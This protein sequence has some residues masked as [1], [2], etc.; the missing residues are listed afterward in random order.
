MFP[1]LTSLCLLLIG[2][3]ET[4]LASDRNLLAEP[5]PLR[6]R[7]I[8]TSA[9]PASYSPRAHDRAPSLAPRD[10]ADPF[11]VQTAFKSLA[12]AEAE[13]APEDSRVSTIAVLSDGSSV[14][15]LPQP[16]P[17]ARE[18]PTPSTA[19]PSTAT[20]STATKEPASELAH[21]GTTTAQVANAPTDG[22]DE[23]SPRVASP[24]NPV[25]PSPPVEPRRLSFSERVER[26]ASTPSFPDPMQMLA[27]WNPESDTLVTAG[28]ALALVLGLLLVTV[29]LL[30]KAQPRSSRPL[31]KEVAEVLGRAPLGGRNQAQLLRLGNKLVLVSV[32]P[33]HAET[34]CEITDEA[35][36]ARLRAL[37]DQ[38]GAGSA[39]AFDEL[40]GQMAN[41]PADHG[42][43]GGGYDAQQ[44]AA[45]YANTPGGR[46][47]A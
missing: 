33:D 45:A 24:A 34:I 8:V 3:G 32:T 40:F 46:R 44:L 43:L 22:V 26:P 36:V 47:Y 28:S 14:G 42:F 1:R 25:E 37:C 10:A 2:C 39:A 7:P 5:N 17:P 31:P 6:S 27:S 21:P 11:A 4:L 18:A 19:T 13:A 30:R 41:E 16:I 38:H 35:E 12:I 29:W 23:E 9:G 15:A 20:P